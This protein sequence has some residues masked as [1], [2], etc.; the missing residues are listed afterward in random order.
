MNKILIDSNIKSQEF[1]LKED[2]IIF[3][4][5]ANC[6]I[7]YKIENDI[8]IFECLINS[9]VTCTYDLNFNLALNIFT[10]DSSNS[11]ILNLNKE[12]IKLDYAYSTLNINDNDYK[13]TI[14]HNYNNQVSRIINH[15]LNLENSKLNFLINAIVPK[16]SDNVK[17]NQD[18]QIIVLKD[19]NSLIKPNLLID[20]FDVEANHSA[21]I[22]DF[23]QNDLFYLTS[24]GIN[25]LDARKLLAKSFL[26]GHMNISFRE[27]N[28][29][30]EKLDIYWR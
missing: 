11:L 7:N 5:N 20:N 8:K 26:I 14:N 22:G 3:Y 25:I 17:T 27:I 4:E 15:G 1:I 2:T 24:R 6:K 13:I 12:E 29:I 21:Y 18:S 16:T 19:N 23:K 28:I 9:N 10:V 30:L